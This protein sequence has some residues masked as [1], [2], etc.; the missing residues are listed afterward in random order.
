MSHLSVYRVK[1]AA[2]SV[3][4]AATA[5]VPHTWGVAIPAA[6][7]LAASAAAGPQQL[8]QAALAPARLLLLLVLRPPCAPQQLPG[9]R[10][11]HV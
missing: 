1:V 4:R 6:H 11:P 3:C 7:T 8:T 5:A 9:W 10:P 2:G